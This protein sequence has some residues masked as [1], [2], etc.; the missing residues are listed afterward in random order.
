MKLESK[1]IAVTAVIIAILIVGTIAGVAYIVSNYTERTTDVYDLPIQISIAG[2]GGPSDWTGVA[3][4]GE[5]YDFN[6]EMYAENP[7]NSD[8]ESLGSLNFTFTLKCVASPCNATTDVI[9]YL[10]MND[11][12]QGFDAHMNGSAIDMYLTI[13]I[14]MTSGQYTSV[15]G[16]IVFNSVGR[17]TVG[18]YAEKA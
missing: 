13:P 2:T 3:Y 1:F 7:Y 11:V 4:K 9:L 18:I 16:Q 12:W 8:L 6:L 17:V 15:P 10:Y 5:I 14:T